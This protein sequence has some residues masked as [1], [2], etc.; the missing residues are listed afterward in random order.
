MLG[1][2]G[3]SPVSSVWFTT[4]GTPLFL[5]C[6]CA[7]QYIARALKLDKIM[8]MVMVMIMIMVMVIAMNN[9]A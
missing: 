6:G 3:R 9:V 8:V 1:T 4:L 2:V 5:A 7:H